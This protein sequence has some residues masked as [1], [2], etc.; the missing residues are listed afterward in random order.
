MKSLEMVPPGR[1]K[2]G[3]QKQ[4]CM[5]CDNRDIRDIEKTEDEVRIRILFSCS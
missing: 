3:R 4:R 2:G 1:I 5:D